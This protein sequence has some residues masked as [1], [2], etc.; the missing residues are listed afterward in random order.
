DRHTGASPEL[1][2]LGTW[3]CLLVPAAVQTTIPEA[4]RKPGTKRPSVSFV[5]RR[6]GGCPQKN[7]VDSFAR[8]HS[9]S[10]S[11]SSHSCLGGAPRNQQQ[12]TSAVGHRE[13]SMTASKTARAVGWG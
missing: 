1:W 7:P 8:P 5:S 10:S 9:S 3:A 13:P 2:I 12:G 4:G 11:G 6:G